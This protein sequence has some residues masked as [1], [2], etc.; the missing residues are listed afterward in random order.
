M[1]QSRKTATRAPATVDPYVAA[2]LQGITA[3][4]TVLNLAKGVRIFSQGDPTDA[5]YFIESGKVKISVISPSGRE[6]VIAMLGPHDFLGEGCLV[7]QTL[8]VSSATST[9]PST[10]S[11]ANMRSMLRALSTQPNLS[12]KS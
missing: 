3:G 5:I 10:L 7:G 4:K 9:E 2:L 8:R 1:P 12:E 6:A 11:R